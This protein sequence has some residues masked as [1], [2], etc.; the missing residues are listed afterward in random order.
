MLFCDN[1][2]GLWKTSG[3]TSRNEHK[4]YNAM[5]LIEIADK[6]LTYAHYRAQ[7]DGLLLEGKTTGNTQTPEKVE[8]TR[9]NVQRMSRLD[10][11]IA[12]PVERNIQL[13]MLETDVVWLVVGEGWCGDCAQILPVMNKIAEA[14]SGRIELKIVSRDR[15]PEFTEQYKAMSVP[16]LLVTDKH[17]GELLDTWGPRPAPAQ[18]IMLKWKGSNG[19]ITKADFELELHTWYAKDRGLTTI[20]ELMNLIHE[21]KRMAS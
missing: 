1:C 16:K 14:S 11:T 17:T 18:Q 9:L 4:T 7:I 21:H 10:K 13:R 2:S 6:G 8:F 3:L 5:N 19:A 20:N 12:L 15:Y